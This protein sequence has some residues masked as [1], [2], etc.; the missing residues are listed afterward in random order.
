MAQKR[1]TE[2]IAVEA[3]EVHP[4]P[5]FSFQRRSHQ[6]LCINTSLSWEPLFMSLDRHEMDLQYSRGTTSL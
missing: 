5:Q 2:H 4:R 6:I 1:C 3:M